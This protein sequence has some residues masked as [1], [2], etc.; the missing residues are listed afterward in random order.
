MNYRRAP[1]DALESAPALR[2]WLRSAIGAALRAAAKRPKAVSRPR[3]K[4][5]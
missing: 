2:P 3:A 4:R 5:T 1:D